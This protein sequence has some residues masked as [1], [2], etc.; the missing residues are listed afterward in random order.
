MPTTDKAM[1]YGS[2]IS[3]VSNENGML[4]IKKIG[5]ESGSFPMSPMV[6]TSKPNIKLIIVSTIIATKGDGIAVPNLGK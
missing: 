1:E 2:M 5:S 6:L 3:K 4:G